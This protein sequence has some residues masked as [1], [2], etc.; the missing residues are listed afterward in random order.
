M[1]PESLLEGEGHTEKTDIWSVGI[2]AFELSTGKT[3]YD[4]LGSYDQVLSITSKEPPELPEGQWSSSFRDFVKSC[5]IKDADKRPS[6]KS[7]LRHP[8]IKKTKKV[9]RKKLIANGLL[10][11]LPPLYQRFEKVHGV[12]DG[13][14]VRKTGSKKQVIFTFDTEEIL[15]EIQEKE[16]V[17]PKPATEAHPQQMG[18]FKVTVVQAKPV[19]EVEGHRE[20]AHTL[21]ESGVENGGGK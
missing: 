1:S 8:F 13:S 4:H 2:T 12:S 11:N 16:R 17:V 3:P 18:R 14:G 6:A 19:G 20:E 10:S 21:V 7:L 15:A 9:D 5:L